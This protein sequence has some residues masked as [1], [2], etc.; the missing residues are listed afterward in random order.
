ML[1]RLTPL[2]VPCGAPARAARSRHASFDDA[3]LHTALHQDVRGFEHHAG[4][5]AVVRGALTEVPRVDVGAEHDK[6]IGLLAPLDLADRVVT[7]VRAGDDLV[8]DLHISPRV[9]AGSGR[10]ARR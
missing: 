5:R 10:V 1:R 3:R 4:P 9:L 6:L 8:R 7:N 2:L